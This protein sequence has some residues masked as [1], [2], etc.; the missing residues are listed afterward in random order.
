MNDRPI[1]L[2]NPQGKGK[3]FLEFSLTEQDTSLKIP[4]TDVSLAAKWGKYLSQE[5]QKLQTNS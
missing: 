5:W 2:D 3:S 4:F 1:D